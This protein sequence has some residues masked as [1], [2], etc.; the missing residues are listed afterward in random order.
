MPGESNETKKETDIPHQ[1]R[2]K[3]PLFERVLFG[4]D[5]DYQEPIRPK[6]KT[7]EPPR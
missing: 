7:Y 3:Q 1:T 2:T 5:R 6:S 4:I